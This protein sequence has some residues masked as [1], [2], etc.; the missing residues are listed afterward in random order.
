VE[1]R[2]P[3]VKD[4]FLKYRHLLDDRQVNRWFRN[5]LRGSAVTAAEQ[6]RRLGWICEHFD[7]TPQELAKKMRKG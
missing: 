2:L 5:N 6:L 4:T 3:R 7:T 1:K